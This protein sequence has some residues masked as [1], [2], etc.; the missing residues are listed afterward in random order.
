VILSTHILP[1]VAV[2]C[3]RVVIINKGRWSPRTRPTT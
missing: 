3:G 1:E 2:T